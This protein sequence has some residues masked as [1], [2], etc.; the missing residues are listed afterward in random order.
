MIGHGM[1]TKDSVLELAATVPNP[2]D[3]LG[4]S[5]RIIARAKRLFAA[6]ERSGKEN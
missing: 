1:V 2:E 6:A 3:D 4:L 5:K